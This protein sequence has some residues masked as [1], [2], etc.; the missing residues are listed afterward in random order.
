M[1]G[2]RAFHSGRHPSEGGTSA[3]RCQSRSRFT[4]AELVIQRLCAR[5]LR[6]RHPGHN[7]TTSAQRHSLPAFA[8]MTKSGASSLSDLRADGEKIKRTQPSRAQG[9]PLQKALPSAATAATADGMKTV[10][11]IR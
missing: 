10:T 5:L 4:T 7:A 1:I 11:A 2:L 8:E 3:N 6:K 9:A